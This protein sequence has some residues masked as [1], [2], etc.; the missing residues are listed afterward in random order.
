[1]NAKNITIEGNTITCLSP[2][3]VKDSPITI[4][5]VAEDVFIQNNQFKVKDASG[6]YIKYIAKKDKGA[7]NIRIKGNTI[8][9]M[10]GKNPAIYVESNETELE[11]TGNEIEYTIDKGNKAIELKS[12]KAPLKHKQVIT[13][14]K[15]RN[16]TKEI[17]IKEIKFSLPKK[18]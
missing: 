4:W 10:S 12:F 8:Q 7:K 9:S 2:K 13:K 14:N 17:N 6:I 18:N 3:S 15:Y 16:V 11:I 5:G 1:M